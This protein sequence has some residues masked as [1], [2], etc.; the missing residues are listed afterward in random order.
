MGI[1]K[2]I[3]QPLNGTILASVFEEAKCGRRAES[4][5]SILVG[6]AVVMS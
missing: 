4:A 1:Y 5:L 6:G 2:S 3:C